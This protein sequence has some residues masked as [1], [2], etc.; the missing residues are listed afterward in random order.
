M[1]AFKQRGDTLV[2]VMLSMALLGLV[3]VG[4]FSVMQR[5]VGLAQNALE[6][7]QTRT[8]ISAQAEMLNYLRDQYATAVAKGSSTTIYPMNVWASIKTR[9]LANRNT[10]PTSVSDCSTTAPTIMA[11]S[12]VIDISSG[13]IALTPFTTASYAP[14]NTIWVEPVGS[15]AS[16][17]PAFQNYIDLYIKTCYASSFGGAPQLMSTVV[18]LYDK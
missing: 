13:T 5:G 7:S 16:A 12:F 11:N 14:G 17:N 6:R 8:E 1:L 10:A 15:P 3:S 18:R 2:E 9:A 4:V